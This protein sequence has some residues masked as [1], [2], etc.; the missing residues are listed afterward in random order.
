[1][2]LSLINEIKEQVIVLD[3]SDM[4]VQ[5]QQRWP[6]PKRMECVLQIKIFIKEQTI[7][8]LAQ[9]QEEWENNRVKTN[10]SQAL[11]PNHMTRW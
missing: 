3:L 1:M 11:G 9:F 5:L 2:S 4:I 7:R 10:P 6:F 8:E